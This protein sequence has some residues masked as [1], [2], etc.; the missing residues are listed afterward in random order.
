MVLKIC[1]NF[2]NFDELACILPEVTFAFLLFV[3]SFISFKSVGTKEITIFHSCLFFL[4][5]SPRKR[6]YE[7]CKSNNMHS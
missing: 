2:I 4:T 1:E 6:H 7:V 3:S 5:I